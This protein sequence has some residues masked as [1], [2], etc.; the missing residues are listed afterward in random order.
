M[1][2]GYDSETD[3]RNPTGSVFCAQGSGYV[4]PWDEVE[5]HLHIP[6]LKNESSQGYRQVR[7]TVKEEELKRVVNMAG[8]QNKKAESKVKLRTKQKPRTD[9]KVDKVELAP[10]LPDCLIVDGY[11]MIYAWDDLKDLIKTDVES[12]RDQLVDMLSNYQGYRNCRLIVVFDGYRVKNNPGET[13]RKGD[14]HI[15]F[16]RQ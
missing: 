14:T 10:K 1:E 5:E 4:V 2:R 11:N 3:F 12:A 13:I 8:G 7:Y 15:I 16:T 9:I 6:I